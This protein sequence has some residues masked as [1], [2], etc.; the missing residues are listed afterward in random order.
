MSM[1]FARLFKRVTAFVME[2]PVISAA[3]PLNNDA[4]IFVV[5][6]RLHDNWLTNYHALR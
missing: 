6:M 5:L 4:R 2:M 1:L 3:R